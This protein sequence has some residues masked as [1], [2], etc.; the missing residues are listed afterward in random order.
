MTLSVLYVGLAALVVG[1][2]GG[3]IA[4]RALKGGRR[5]AEASAAIDNVL[6]QVEQSS[7]ALNARLDA[8]TGEMNRTFAQSLQQAT[9]VLTGSIGTVREETRAA[10]HDK[11]VQVTERLGDLKSTNER[12]MEFSRS[13]DEFQRMLQSP[14]LRGDFG[15]F[16]L[17]QMLKDLLPSEHYECQA[18]IGAARVDALIKT[19]YGALCIDCKFPLDNFRRAL[20]AKEP[21]GRDAAMKLFYSDVRGRMDEIADRYVSPPLTLEM[22]FMFVPAENVYY[23]LIGRPELLTYG[24]ERR[25]VAVSPNTMYA[26]V[27]VLAVGFRG[28]KIQDEARRVQQILAELGSR[29]EKFQDHFTMIG[30]HLDNAKNQFERALRDVERFDATLQDVKIGRLE[31][32]QRPLAEIG[33]PSQSFGVVSPEF[34][35]KLRTAAEAFKL[36][37]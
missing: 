13:L 22:A 35:G 6:W 25:V 9:Q 34:A 8:V 26:Y 19:P 30:K 11:F 32:T 24:R 20:E 3:A 29:F 1:V 16:T 27:Q 17:E 21:A 31:E 37:I 4:V 28:M 5:S 23:E 14:K 15:E 7:R 36:D 33:P 18:A 10:I 2:I 12:I